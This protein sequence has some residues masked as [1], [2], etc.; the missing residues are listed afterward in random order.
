MNLP[1]KFPCELKKNI[2]VLINTI[3]KRNGDA[4]IIIVGETGSAKTYFGSQIAYYI[5][6]YYKRTNDVENEMFFDG[7]AYEKYAR[8]QT[9]RVL[10]MDESY[11]TMS[12]K[13]AISKVNFE[14][15]TMLRDVRM[16]SHVHIFLMQDLWDFEKYVVFQRADLMIYCYKM[17]NFKDM[18]L[19]PGYY[20]IYGRKKIRKVYIDGAR[21]HNM[22][23]MY[24]DDGHGRSD[25]VIMFDQEKYDVLKDRYVARIK[26]KEKREKE[27]V[28]KTK[29]EL[30]KYNISTL[31]EIYDIS[32]AEIGKHIGVHGSMLSKWKIQFKPKEIEKDEE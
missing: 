23:C 11:S 17:P 6:Q 27:N 12:S 13:R 24:S 3:E 26:G 7:K 9:K 22:N 20:K 18:T 25:N 14:F 1:F 2:D 5:N 32:Q 4:V 16:R 31:S 19:D 15:G 10:F 28:L 30:L 8:E 21:Y 29:F